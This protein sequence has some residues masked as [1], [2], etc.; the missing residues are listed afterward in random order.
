M[1]SLWGRK[2][3][4]HI[5][6]KG[7]K[8]KNFYDPIY[9]HIGEKIL[10]LFLSGEIKNPD[11]DLISILE[12]LGMRLSLD[13]Y[14]YSPTP[15][16][17]IEDIIYSI[18]KI[19]PKGNTAYILPW[20]IVEEEIY[21][22]LYRPYFKIPIEG[23]KPKHGF[24]QHNY[25]YNGVYH[26]H[27]PDKYT[28]DFYHDLL[29]EYIET[30][31]ETGGYLILDITYIHTME[32]ADQTITNL[33]KYIEPVAKRTILYL[34]ISRSFIDPRY[35]V[36]LSYTSDLISNSIKEYRGVPPRFL[37]DK[38]LIRKL[39]TL[40]TLWNDYIHRIN[41]YI[42]NKRETINKYLGELIALESPYTVTL[43]DEEYME[44][45]ERLLDRDV[46][47]EPIEEPLKGINI[48]IYTDADEDCFEELA[49]LLKAD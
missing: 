7:K 17:G 36:A 31:L 47:V 18:D 11:I 37:I 23:Y 10:N 6:N 44:T 19:L 32:R 42:S 30:I 2:V 48:N 39:F 22:T 43:E 25:E 45:S 34:D 20:Y 13:T 3:S 38:E 29:K 12:S 9:G 46:I 35:E 8:V 5:L 40:D 41:E 1:Q 21:R 14:G 24:L 49:V 26:L 16:R 33:I 15:I 28:G 27:I 4:N